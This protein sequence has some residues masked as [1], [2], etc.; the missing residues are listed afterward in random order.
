MKITIKSLKK[1]EY[2]VEIASD[3]LLIKD[4]KA[5]IENLDQSDFNSPIVRQSTF[6]AGMHNSID[7]SNKNTTIKPK[8]EGLMNQKSQRKSGRSISRRLSLTQE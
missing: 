3:E 6:G 4:L 7:L 5:E 8:L 2:E 1:V